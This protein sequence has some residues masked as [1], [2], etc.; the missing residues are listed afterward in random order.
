MTLT[1][2]LAKYLVSIQ[3]NSLSEKSIPQYDKDNIEMISQGPSICVFNKD[4]SN[5]VLD[6]K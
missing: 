6:L 4:D 1:E 5:E 2:Q 3:F